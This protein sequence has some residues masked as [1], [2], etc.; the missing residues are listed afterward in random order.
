MEQ[1]QGFVTTG[2]ETWVCW[3]KKA[4]YGLKQAS[5]AWNSN[6]HA[7]LT[8]LGFKWTVTD[9]G[10]YIMHQWEGDGP[11][12]V[13]LYVDDITILG[14]SL[15]VVKELKVN[16]AKHYEISDLGEIEL[17]LGIC[18]TRDQQSKCLTIDQSC[19]HQMVSL[20]YLYSQNWY[21]LV[22]WWG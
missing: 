15:E 10:V 12:Y 1:P 19:H 21:V 3:L 22:V 6:I 8:E 9:A 18:I 7:A 11:L 2:K 4:I 5:H 13:I 16:L 17:Y 14:A 20:L